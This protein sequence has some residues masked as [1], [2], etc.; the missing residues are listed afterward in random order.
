MTAQID[1]AIGAGVAT[2]LAGQ[3]DAQSGL[4]ALKKEV[5]GLLDS[6]A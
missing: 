2:I 6:N 5:Q 4:N 1:A 3:V